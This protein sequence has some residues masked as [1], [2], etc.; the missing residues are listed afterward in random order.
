MS[1][2]KNR[3]WL[4]LS[5]R[6][7][8][9]APFVAAALCL[10]ALVGG[11]LEWSGREVDRIARE[12]D[13]STVSLLLR[14]SVDR[15]AHAQESST[16]WDDAVREMRQR[17]LDPGWLD[18]NLGIWFHDYAGIDEVYLLSPDDRPLYAMRG[19][20]R[21]DPAAYL[22]VRDVAADLV[23]RLRHTRQ[24]ARRRDGE[25]A[26]L[27]P[28]RA[29]FAPVRGRP[30]IVSAKPI[31]SDSGGIVQPHGREAVHLAVV[32]LDNGYFSRLGRH[33]GLQNARFASVPGRRRGDASVALGG[34][35]SGT[36]GYLVWTPFA[37]GSRVTSAIGPVVLV[38][39]LLAAL[40]IWA[41]AS[42]LARRTEDLEHSRLQ[43]HHQATHDALTGLANRSMFELRLDE[44]IARSRRRGSDVALLY[45][46]LDRF[47][48]VND[49]LGHPAGDALIREVALRL[50]QQVRGYDVVARLG[51]DEFA[52]VISD[53]AEFASIEGICARIIAEMERPF[54]LSGS[55][56]YIG[57]SIGIACAPDHGIDRTELTRKADIALYKAKLDGRSRFVF[58]TP[59]LDADVRS[60]EASY[61]ELRQALVEPDRQFR[62]V[63]QPTFASGSGEITGVEALLRWQHP[64][65]GL[66]APSRFI[67]SAEE[68][69]LIEALGDWVLHRV[70]QDARAW[71]GIR[72]AVNVS[73]V[74]LRSRG[75]VDRLR[76]AIVQH[77]FPAARLELEL[78]ETALMSA[79]DDVAQTLQELRGLGVACALDDFGTGYSS[80]SHIRDFAVD[81]IKI[82]RSFVHAVDTVPGAALVEAIV[83]LARAN[84]L[85]LTAEGVETAEQHDFLRRV[86]CQ[87]VQGFFF[88]QPL[89]AS[90][91]SDLL[92][93]NRRYPMGISMPIS[94]LAC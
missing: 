20:E 41:L 83:G 35:G 29:D 27:T 59:E 68:S 37:P 16:L 1:P 45:L 17:P 39:M 19:G 54:D 63:Y 15:I 48:Q 44:V 67:H 93:Q 21:V 32:F 50:T 28:G 92:A 74:Q 34:H 52:I 6:V 70:L 33:Y 81:R 87:E 47:K 51:G 4:R 94:M 89:S 2:R 85:R 57:A 11:L 14:Q 60:R 72:L 90:D 46:D 82:D 43:A 64:E 78:T 77:D 71:E 31:L 22:D 23:T 80:L 3:L 7:R 49:T 61:R 69:G 40:A 73:P 65:L 86:G 13:R 30:A 75:F 91:L 10:L 26:M 25:I 12:R 55:Q 18:L 53:P 38:G 79:S 84:G 62:L 5:P 76:C 58:F 66:V 24:V 42:R 36:L 8:F 9:T 88:A 56:A